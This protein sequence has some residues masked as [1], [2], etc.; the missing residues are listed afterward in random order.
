MKR[1][2]QVFCGLFASVLTL[3]SCLSS[4]DNESTTYDDMAIKTF[5][6][7][8]LNRYLHTTSKAGTDSVYKSTFS[9]T[10][11]KMNIDQL[12]HRIW[13]ADS[14]PVG[15]DGSRVVCT[16]TTKN[17]GFVYVKSQLY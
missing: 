6:L 4:S 13:N 1:I 10:D 12:N 16:V 9:A 15:T 11:Q 7:G 3:T 2:L 8:K 17:N 5:A 14:L